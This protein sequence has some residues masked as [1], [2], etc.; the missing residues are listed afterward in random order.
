MD[1]EARTPSFGDTLHANAARFGS[2]PRLAS[3]GLL[4]L[5]NPELPRHGSCAEEGLNPQE[6]GDENQ[7]PAD[8]ENR[9]CGIDKRP[10]L[11]VVLT[12]SFLA[13][14]NCIFNV[15]AQL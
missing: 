15:H 8:S 10:L 4:N 1:L 5:H 6:F 3:A 2:L 12:S 14:A 9:I 11:P 13:S 7:P